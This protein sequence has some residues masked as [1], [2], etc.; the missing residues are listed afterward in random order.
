V[1]DLRKRGVAMM[2]VGQRMEEIYAVSDRAVVLL[3]GKAIA[4]APIAE[5][6]RDGAIQLM[7]GRPLTDLYPK[8]S[9]TAGEIVIAVEGLSRGTMFENVSFTLRSGEILDFA[10]WS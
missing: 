6:P 10:G 2:F 1:D 9:H 8:R 3:D 5:M 7:V 4:G